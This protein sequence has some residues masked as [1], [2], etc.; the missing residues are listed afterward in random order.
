VVGHWIDAERQP[1]TGL[2]ALEVL[3]GYHGSDM[4]AVLQEVIENYKIEDR[5]SAFQ[6]HNAPNNNT[7]W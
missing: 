3:D 2:L 1:K 6:V 7:C 5:I 4:A